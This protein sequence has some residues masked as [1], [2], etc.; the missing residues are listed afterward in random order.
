[1]LPVNICRKVNTEQEIEKSAIILEAY[2]GTKIN[3]VGKI[4]VEVQFGEKSLTNFAVLKENLESLL[5]LETCRKLDIIPQ[6]SEVRNKT[7]EVRNK[8]IK[9]NKFVE[10]NVDV[11]TGRG[12]STKEFE[13]T[14]DSNITPV[15][16]PPRR[17]PKVIKDKLK[18]TLKELEKKNYHKSRKPAVLG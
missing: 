15:A 1:M 8:T 17:V 11:F 10:K 12:Q 14:V 9:T 7:D 6:I 5:G 3:V 13:I 18:S 2:G 4:K 16:N